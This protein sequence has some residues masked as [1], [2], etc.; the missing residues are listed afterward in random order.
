MGAWVKIFSNLT[1]ERGSDYDIE[2]G[3]ASWSKGRLN[4][5]TSVQIIENRLCGVLAVPDTTWHH[6]D[7]YTVLLGKYGT[8]ISKRILR[9]IQA[10]ITPQHIGKR[11]D[12]SSSAFFLYVEL[13][14]T[15]KESGVLIR[16]EVGKWISLYVCSNGKAGFSISSKGKIDDH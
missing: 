15:P 7:R 13:K 2:V 1:S 4:N 11:I 16:Q 3:K 14:S 10:K 9:V 8:N 6:Y 5:I 12:H